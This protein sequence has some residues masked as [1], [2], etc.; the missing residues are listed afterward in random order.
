ML[1]VFRRNCNWK[2]NGEFAFADNCVACSLFRFGVYLLWKWENTQPL[3]G[4]WQPP[5]KHT[6]HL[7]NSTTKTINKIKVNNDGKSASKRQRKAGART[8]ASRNRVGGGGAGGWRRTRVTSSTHFCQQLFAHRQEQR[9]IHFVSL[10][11]FCACF[12]MFV[13]LQIFFFVSR[14]FFLSFKY[15]SIE[16][17]ASKYN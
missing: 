17:I 2:T 8:K 14:S 12:P 4:D 5:H 6:L 13:R 9:N 1:K 3:S 16:H 10:T 11:S 15:M 7:R